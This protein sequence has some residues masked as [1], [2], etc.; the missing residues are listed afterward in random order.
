MDT[1]TNFHVITTTVKSC[2]PMKVTLGDTAKHF[3]T[4]A[5]NFVYIVAIA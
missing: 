3:H 2:N 4:I 1:E 5:T